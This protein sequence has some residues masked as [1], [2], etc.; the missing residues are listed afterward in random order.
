MWLPF[1]YKLPAEVS[2]S[3]NLYYHEACQMPEVTSTT[4][5][6]T[7]EELRRYYVFPYISYGEAV[8]LQSPEGT[9][10]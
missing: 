8:V 5:G 4:A 2:N 1:L 9:E 7:P 10:L 3:K 6:A